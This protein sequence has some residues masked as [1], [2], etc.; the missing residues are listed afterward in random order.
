[1]ESLIIFSCLFILN[2]L[3]N[4]LELSGKKQGNELNNTGVANLENKVNLS[5]N[6]NND[7]N[8]ID[9]LRYMKVHYI[10]VEEGDSIFIELPNEKTM[11]IDAG[12]AVE[13]KKVINYIKQFVFLTSK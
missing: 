1:M 13:G 12:E 8:V 3:L 11:L 7:N 4:Y 6:D 9:N 10:D 5:Q 2:N